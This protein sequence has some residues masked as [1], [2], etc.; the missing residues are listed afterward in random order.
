M[1]YSDRNLAIVAALIFLWAGLAGGMDQWRTPNGFLPNICLIY[2][3]CFAV[4]FGRRL[5]NPIFAI[6]TPTALGAVLILPSLLV[7]MKDE[8]QGRLIVILLAIVLPAVIAAGARFIKTIRPGPQPGQSKDQLQSTARRNRVIGFI[9]IVLFPQLV[10]PAT[11]DV[12]LR[13]REVGDSK[14]ENEAIAG[15]A[16][17]AKWIALVVLGIIALAGFGSLLMASADA[18]L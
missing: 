18:F 11:L 1:R 3:P 12:A 7:F 4:W 8:S 6:G 14:N 13:L 9:G 15:P 2:L 16:E 17:N 10:Q 5:E